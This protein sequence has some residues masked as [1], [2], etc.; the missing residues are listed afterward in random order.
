MFWDILDPPRLSL[1]KNLA[2][3]PPVPR[4]YLAG[5]TALAIMMG[6][7][8][9]V[10]FDWFTPE[11]FDPGILSRRLERFG[12]VKVGETGPGTL[13]RMDRQHP[14]YMALLPQPCS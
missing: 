12:E 7:R 14:G 5:G 6:H 1:L 11:N 9:S 13:Y 8:E 4:S 2:F 3:D 10:D